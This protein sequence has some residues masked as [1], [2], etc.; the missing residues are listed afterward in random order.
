MTNKISDGVN[1][2]FCKIVSGEIPS[3]K[4]YEDKDFF[5]FLDIHP[6][7]PGHTQVIPKNHVRWVWDVP[8]VGEYFEVVR[9]IAK[10]QQ[11]SFE[12]DWILSKI[13]GDEVPHAHIWI[14]PNDNVKGNKND[15]PANAEKISS[16]L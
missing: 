3:H 10:A 14:F 8:N 13:I 2:I 9:K 5:A 11:K 15:F 7:S 1:C 12:T 16:A 4:V 6:Q